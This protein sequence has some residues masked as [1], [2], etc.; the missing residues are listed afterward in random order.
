MREFLKKKSLEN[1]PEE[2]LNV[3]EKAVSRSRETRD[4]FSTRSPGRL[5]AIPK[6]ANYVKSSTL[7]IKTPFLP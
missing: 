1:D 4:D 7:L 3:D 5:A 2:A 6:E